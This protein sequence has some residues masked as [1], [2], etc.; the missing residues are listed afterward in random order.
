M[1]HVLPRPLGR[2]LALTALA[3]LLGAL[4][5]MPVAPAVAA[6]T[7]SRDTVW[8]VGSGTSFRVLGH[9]Y[10]HGHG[11]SQYGAEGAARQGLDHRRILAFYYPGTRLDDAGGRI[12]VW[13]SA[14]DPRAIEVAATDGLTLID[15]GRPA[16]DRRVPL[17]DAGVD[18]WR[19]TGS[20]LRAHDD[21]GWRRVLQVRGTGAFAAGGRP[22]RLLSVSGTPSYRGRLYVARIPSGQPVV[23]NALGLE[24][25]LRGVVPRE[26]PA[27]W[28]PA[29]VQAQAVAARTYAVFERFPGNTTYDLCDTGAC[30]VY[31]GADAEQPASDAAIEAT[32]HEILT[33]D[34]EPAFTQFGSSNGGWSAAG[35]QPYLR[36]VEDPY[37]GWSG[38]PVHTWRTRLSVASIEKAYPTLGELRSVRV[39]G[40]DGNG[41]WGGR[42]GGVT[43]VGTDATVRVSGDAFRSTFGLRSTWFTLRTS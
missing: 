4:V 43:L 13:L 26:I 37:D 21:A 10:G 19:L 22:I 6:G 27:S 34:G 20:V 24:T 1:R 12:R 17:D 39:T 36:A 11:M 42:V 9:G 38:N 5:G 2:I 3:P 25:Y 41:D 16:G 30:Q 40:R 23:V 35:S 14:A 8:Q 18:R 28:S 7:A 29:A 32:E 31:A 33:A 15:D